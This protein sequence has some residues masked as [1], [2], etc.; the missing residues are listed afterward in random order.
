MG[1][2]EALPFYDTYQEL[3][4]ENKPAIFRL[5][6]MGVDAYELARR[7][8][9]IQALPGSR[10]QGATGTLSAAGDGRIYRELP[11]AQFSSGVPAPVFSDGLGDAAP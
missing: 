11:W 5:M 8:P 10:M 3:K 6:A 7:M 2:A 4:A 9:Q 1:G